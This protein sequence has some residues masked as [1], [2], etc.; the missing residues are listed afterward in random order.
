MLINNLQNA[1]VKELISL[2]SPDKAN[3][4]S[5]LHLSH[6]LYLDSLRPPLGR[7]QV[8]LVLESS[9]LVLGTQQIFNKYLST[10]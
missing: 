3:C 8:S 4:S 5:S 10:N 7:F 6:S 2:D 9:T 1:K